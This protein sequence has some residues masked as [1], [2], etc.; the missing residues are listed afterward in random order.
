RAAQDV[1]FE[2][3]N[4]A[5]A[6]VDAEYAENLKVKEAL[7][8]E[9]EALV[10]VRGDLEKAKRALR[11]IQDRWDVAGKVPRGDIGRVEGR[12]RAVEQS[13]R[14]VESDQWR[15]SNPRVRARAEGAAAQLESAIE[16]LEKDLATAEASGDDKAIARAS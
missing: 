6:A 2:A 8:T 7:L 14:D 1:F 15:T 11:D 12:L 5:N 13:I 16:G 10:P 9:A 4:A 3:R